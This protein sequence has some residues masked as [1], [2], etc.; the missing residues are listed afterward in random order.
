M[1]SFFDR[2]WYGSPWRRM[3]QLQREMDGLVGGSRAT[4]F[5]PVNIWRNDDGAVV[6]AEVPGAKAEDLD[7]CT[8]GTTL[9]IRGRRKADECG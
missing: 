1:L 8:E 9:T 4:A 2:A 7:I 3:R 6:T 5:P